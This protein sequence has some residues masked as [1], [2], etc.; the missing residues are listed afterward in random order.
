MGY[1]YLCLC[2]HTHTHT[3]TDI[4]RE[5]ERQRDTH[6]Q[7]ER[8]RER[9]LYTYFIFQLTEVFQLKLYSFG[10]KT[11]IIDSPS[12]VNITILSNDQPYG[13]FEFAADNTTIYVGK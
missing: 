10:N 4:D 9:G 11:S 6:T 12:N 1:I 3:Q 8:E 2:T 7:R 13:Y 5:R